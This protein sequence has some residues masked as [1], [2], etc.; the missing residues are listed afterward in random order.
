MEQQNKNETNWKRKHEGTDK[1]GIQ[2]EEMHKEHN[3]KLNTVPNENQ[4][5]TKER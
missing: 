2:K 3:R 1:K 4:R 5:N